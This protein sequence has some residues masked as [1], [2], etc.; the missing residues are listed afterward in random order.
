MQDTTETN[1]LA[2]PLAG[3][4]T[5]DDYVK[6]HQVIR[7][8]EAGRWQFRENRQALVDAGAVAFMVGRMWVNPPKADACLLSI[9]QE[10]AKRRAGVP[11]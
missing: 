10:A 5:F 6:D 7:S 4:V 3:W 11:A 1:T 2:G 9:G 8:K